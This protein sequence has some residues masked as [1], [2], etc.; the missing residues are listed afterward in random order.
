MLILSSVGIPHRIELKD[1]LF[2]LFVS[3][4]VEEKAQYEIYC[5]EK[6]NCN[7][8]PA[9]PVSDNF[10][11]SFKPFSLILIVLLALFF[12]ITGPWADQSIWFQVGAG[13]SG[14]IIFAHHL[15]LLITPLTLHADLVHLFGNCIIGFFILHFLLQLTGNGIGTLAVLLTAAAGNYLNILLHG[16]GHT[17]VGFSTAVFSAIG[18]LTTLQLY[19]TS[20]SGI[21]GLT[22]FLPPMAGLALLALLGTGGEQTDVGAHLF[23]LL[24]GSLGGLVLSFFLL[25][26]RE[27]LLAQSISLLLSFILI[28]GSWKISFWI[29][30]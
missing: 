17:F 27:S 10:T 2:Q 16:S 22:L 28:T 19:K 1:K 13:Q 12:N 11:L 4:K 8:P 24:S 20:T 7:W 26:I 29:G 18:L 6:E 21:K 25:R 3:T 15:H 23:G 5:Y 14:K 9:K 30:G